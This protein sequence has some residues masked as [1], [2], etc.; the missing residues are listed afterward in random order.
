MESK[1]TGLFFS[2]LLK[3]FLGAEEF[4][5]VIEAVDADFE[6]AGDHGFECVECAVDY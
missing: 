3:N 6:A 4:A 5:V 1:G 2:A